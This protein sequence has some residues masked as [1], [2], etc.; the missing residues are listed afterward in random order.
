MA[1]VQFGEDVTAVLSVY[2]TV[3]GS[4]LVAVY[5]LRRALNGGPLHCP[6]SECEW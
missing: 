5:H 1:D 2:A 6:I 3:D 4:I